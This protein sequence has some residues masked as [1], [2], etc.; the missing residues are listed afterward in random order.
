MEMRLGRSRPLSQRIVSLV[1]GICQEC[2]RVQH[3]TVPRRL[4]SL[5]MT[6]KSAAMTLFKR[7]EPGGDLAALACAISS[8]R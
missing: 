1:A 7:Y 8:S 5:I 3:P 4:A 2:S 6:G